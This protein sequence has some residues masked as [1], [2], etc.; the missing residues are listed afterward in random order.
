MLSVFD[1]HSASRLSIYS[2]C[3]LPTGIIILSLLI[4]VDKSQHR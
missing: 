3:L 2:F 4:G 1:M